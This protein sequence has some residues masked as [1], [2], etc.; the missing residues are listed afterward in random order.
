MKIIGI[1]PI[2]NESP[3]IDSFASSVSKVCDKI[4]VLDDGSTDNSVEL[5]EKYKNIEVVK[6]ENNDGW[7][8]KRGHL[9]NLARDCSATHIVSLDADESFTSN[10]IK[11]FD[12]ITS[13]IKPGERCTMHWLPMWRSLYEYRDDNSAWSN[14]YKDFIICDDGKINYSGNW[15]HEPRLPIVNQTKQIPS[16]VGAVFHFQFSCWEAFQIKQSWYRCLERV[17]NPNKSTSE[18]NSTYSITLYDGNCKT[19]KAPSEWYE[20]VILPNIDEIY[21]NNNWRIKEINNWF[22]KYGVDYFRDLN[23]WHV[24]EINNLKNI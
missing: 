16:N 17:K 11:N 22:E 1:T 4:I 10:A 3:F 24:D 20:N 15:I 13:S 12:L 2:K 7:S 14:S 8:S 6:L 19:T 21:K 5:L 9:F 23:I 18:I